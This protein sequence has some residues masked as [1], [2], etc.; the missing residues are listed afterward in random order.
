MFRTL[1]NLRKDVEISLHGYAY[2][3]DEQFFDLSAIA[4]LELPTNVFV[5]SVTSLRISIKYPKARQ[6]P[7]QLGQSASGS[8]NRL[9]KQHRN[10][11]HLALEVRKSDTENVLE[12]LIFDQPY[13]KSLTLHGYLKFSEMAWSQWSSLPWANLESLVVTSRDA[14][15][16]LIKRLADVPLPSLQTIKLFKLYAPWEDSDVPEPP[17]LITFLGSLHVTQLALSEYSAAW[18]LSYLE[19]DHGAA[20]GRLRKLRIQTSTYLETEQIQCIGARC[21]GLEWLG[22]EASRDQLPAVIGAET[23]MPL[24]DALGGLPALRHLHIRVCGSDGHLEGTDVVTMFW[25]MQAARRRSGWPPLESLKVS[26]VSGCNLRHCIVTDCGQGR[27]LV[28]NWP[29]RGHRTVR[30]W[31]TE[32]ME[33]LKTHATKG[34]IN[35]FMDNEFDEYGT[36]SFP[37]ALADGW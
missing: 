17:E 16:E 6:I 8:I 10:L 26:R 24:L 12:H 25:Y 13:L 5:P 32:K 15:H 29:R 27:A 18:F 23:P 31:D 7:I 11:K 14:S 28:N 3:E 4:P 19:H 1:K 36:A 9:L 34:L 2:P 33:E 21:P 22:L 37:S 30:V 20:A 35:R